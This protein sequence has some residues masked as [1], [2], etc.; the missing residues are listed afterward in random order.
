MKIAVL[1]CRDFRIP[2]GAERMEIDMAIALDATIVCL[3]VDPD[4][5]EIYPLSRKVTFHPLHRALPGEPFRQLLGMHLFR[6]LNLPYDFFI[7]MDDMALRYLVHP[8]PH[9]YYLHTPR[10]VFYDMY[11]PAIRD[12]PFIKRTFMRIILSVFRYLDQRFVAGHVRTI[13]CNSH[14]TRN[15]IWK[16]YQRDATVLYPPVHTE[17]YENKGYKDYWL[18]VTRVDKWK[19]IELLIDTFRLL[20]DIPL[21]IAGKIYPRYREL[22]R[23]APDNITFLDSISDEELVSLY[24]LC[25]GFITTA[26]DEDFGITPVEA[27]ASGKPVVAVREG[28]YQETVV[29]GYTGFLVAPDKD[30]LAR[31]I[32]D[33]DRDPSRFAGEARRVAERFD[34]GIFREAFVSFV[35]T[36]AENQ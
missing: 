16:A 34:Y 20:P 11:Y 35:N 22:A 1:T 30:E 24:S 31:A 17:L 36:S 14:N 15:R 19:R 12:Y 10:R 8:V 4:F 27:M 21:I 18:A 23:K 9:I 32:S 25:R 13:A 26:I 3:S 28:G 5:M 2:G 7:V 29:D 33:I 6:H